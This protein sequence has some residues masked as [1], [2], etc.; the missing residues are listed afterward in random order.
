[1]EN[2]PMAQEK[3]DI[4]ELLGRTVA[5]ETDGT[6]VTSNPEEV[7]GTSKLRGALLGGSNA[8]GSEEGL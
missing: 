3:T 2:L 7:W 1:M 8:V 4:R 5:A 6:S